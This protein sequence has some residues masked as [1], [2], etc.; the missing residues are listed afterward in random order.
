M[1]SQPDQ[2]PDPIDGQTAPSTLRMSHW[3][4]ADGE[5]IT[6]AD[7]TG[8]DA[9]YP[10]DVSGPVPAGPV[11]ATAANAATDQ[12]ADLPLEEYGTVKREKLLGR[13]SYLLIALLLLGGGFTLGAATKPAAAPASATTG[14]NAIGRAGGF[15]GTGGFGAGG[16]GQ[17]GT[18]GSANAGT[19]AVT[20][21][22]AG[23]G[24]GTATGAG[25]ANAAAAG[26]DTLTGTI[27]LIDG[28]NVYIQDAQGTVTKIATDG[29]TAFSQAVPASLATLATGATIT[30]EGAAGADGT[31]TATSVRAG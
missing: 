20:G 25:G 1:N 18:G 21:P 23:A 12:I 4:G 14:A 29:Q 9:L 5:P 13:T 22:P 31:V 15:G 19:G 7:D 6:L 17:R 24:T 3:P 16:G 27:K 30:V 10:L 28:A 8:D 26:P 2:G 11:P